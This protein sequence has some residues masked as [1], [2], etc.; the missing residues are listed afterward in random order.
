MAFNF[1]KKINNSDNDEEETFDEETGE[2]FWWGF[3]CFGWL[4]NGGDV[5]HGV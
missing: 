2:T 5:I 3:A 4:R 1:L